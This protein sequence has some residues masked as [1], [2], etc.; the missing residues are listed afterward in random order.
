MG[1]ADDAAKGTAITLAGQWLRFMIQ[2]LSTAALARLLTPADFGVM[3]MVLSLVGVAAVLGDFGLSLAAIQSQS[4]TDAQRTNL[5]WINLALGSV[6]GIA[7]AA[8][9]PLIAHFYGDD[10]LVHLTYALAIVFFLNAAAAQF[11]A[12]VSRK[13]KFRWLALTDILAQVAAGAAAIWAAS[14]G[15]S[16]WS[17]AVQQ[18]VLFSVTLFLLVVGSRWL[19]GRPRIVRMRE[20]LSFGSNTLGV[21][22]L[23]YASS[24]ADSILVGRFAGAAALG[25]YDRAFQLFRVPLMQIAAPM[26]RVAL[27][28]LSRL[29]GTKDFLKYV[30]TAQSVLVYAMG[31]LFFAAIA[32]SGPLIDTLLGPG[33]DESKTILRILA[34]G[35]V[36][37]ALTYSYFWIFLATAQTRIQ[38][39]FT[40][41]GRSAMIGLMLIGVNWGAHGVAIGASTG[42]GVNWLLLTLLALPRVGIPPRQILGASFRPL[43]IYVLP[44][45]AGI[46]VSDTEVA[47]DRPLIGLLAGATVFTIAFAIVA[48]AVPSIRADL[49]RIIAIARR[50]F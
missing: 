13:L 10:R 42:L 21:Q 9:A 47:R 19:P 25:S 38:L 15:F 33:W 27:P 3:T 45:L 40:I 29:N 31:G 16:Y 2:I 43:A 24:N 1:L 50:A 48:L 34:F 12:E 8:C 5:F 20:L 36:F 44:V 37:Q 46:L 28:I 22:V 32:I 35:G 7:V 39:R 4:I 23:N 49:R 41:I 11:K 14:E 18:I 26:T 6:L 30:L 17:L